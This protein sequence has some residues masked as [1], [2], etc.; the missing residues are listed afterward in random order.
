LF[1]YNLNYLVLVKDYEKIK[2]VFQEITGGKEKMMLFTHKLKMEGKI[3][4]K[5][6]NLRE[7]IIDLIDVKFGMF[8]KS[9][10]EK[11]NQIDNIETLKQIL[12]LVGKSLVTSL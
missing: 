11:V 3:E 7:N 5:I 1:C 10:A 8:D 2:E 12:R 4:G 6:E 9:L